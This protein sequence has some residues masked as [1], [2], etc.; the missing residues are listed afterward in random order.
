MNTT[1]RMPSF[2][3]PHGGGPCF[4]MQWDP[5]HTWDTLAAWLRALPGQLPA[6]PKAILVISGHW[7]TRGHLSVSAHPHPPLIYDYNGF[8]PH[9]YKLAWPAPGAPDVATHIAALLNAQHIPTEQD[10]ARGYDHGVFIPLKVAF[11]DADI[12]TVQLSLHHSL[13]PALHLKI[14]AAV[15]PLRDA[16]VLIIGSGMSYHNMRRYQWNNTAIHG[17]EPADFDAWLEYAVTASPEARMHVLSAWASAPGA[18]DAH[19]RE[20]HLLPLMVAA[21]A[22]EYDA[23]RIVFRDQILGAPISAVRFG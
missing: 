5:P 11:P 12:P 9:T 16:G 1:P 6:R 17:S 21:G 13:D 10:A 19:P 4:F 14:G 20:E 8:P 2:F 18:R 22:A 23:G 3:I 15:A 7:E